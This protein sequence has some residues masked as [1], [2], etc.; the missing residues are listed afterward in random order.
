MKMCFCREIS[1]KRGELLRSCL[2]LE[3]EMRVFDTMRVKIEEEKNEVT[4]VCM[5]L[6]LHHLA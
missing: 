3:S 6:N 2:D 1:K 5:Q 4:Y